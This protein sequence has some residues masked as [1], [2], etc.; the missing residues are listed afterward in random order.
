MMVGCGRPAGWRVSP[1]PPVPGCGQL[2][3]ERCCGR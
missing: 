3:K 1:S 2:E